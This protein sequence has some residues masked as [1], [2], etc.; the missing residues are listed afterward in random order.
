MHYNSF[1]YSLKVWLTSSL[2]APHIYIV[3]FFASR[4]TGAYL[5]MTGYLVLLLEC[6][7]LSM[8]VW[9]AFW[10]SLDAICKARLTLAAKKILAW[11]TLELLLLLLFTVIIHGLGDRAT[12]W[13]SCF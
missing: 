3:Y 5:P 8:P 12:S 13:S 1:Q 7:L 4:G 2:A 11:A 9:F 10:V 6:L